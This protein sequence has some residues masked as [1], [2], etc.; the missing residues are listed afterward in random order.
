[1][2]SLAIFAG[3]ALFGVTRVLVV[4]VVSIAGVSDPKG[5]I[6]SQ[7]LFG[8]VLGVVVMPVVILFVE[9]KWPRIAVSTVATSL[10]CGVLVFPSLRRAQSA[11]EVVVGATT[12]VSCLG[13]LC[14]FF[15]TW[16]TLLVIQLLERAQ[17]RTESK[18]S[19]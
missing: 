7:M 16:L 18:A 2:R 11:P 8:A 19:P 13:A 10:L 4:R 6:P 17:T 14:G 3:I 1:M 5:S 9:R 15:A 12:L